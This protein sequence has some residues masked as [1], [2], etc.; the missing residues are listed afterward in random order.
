MRSGLQDLRRRVFHRVVS[1]SHISLQTAVLASRRRESAHSLFG[2]RHGKPTAYSRRS[3]SR[4]QVGTRGATVFA[5]VEAWNIESTCSKPILTPR[6]SCSCRRTTAYTTYSKGKAFLVHRRRPA[7]RSFW[8]KRRFG[9]H[10]VFMQAMPIL[11]TQLFSGHTKAEKEEKQCPDALEKKEVCRTMVQL[12]ARPWNLG[13]ARPRYQTRS[14]RS[15]VV[16]G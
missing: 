11:L 16:S 8:L 14:I 7:S 9:P 15:A 2:A 1:I 10:P 12:H 6:C 3:R 13:A 5:L 4:A